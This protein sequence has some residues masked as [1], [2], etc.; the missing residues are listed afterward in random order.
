KSV[1]VDALQSVQV[2]ESGPERAMLELTWRIS[3]R[4]RIVQRMCVYA[5]SPRIDFVTDVDWHERQSLLK[6]AFPTSIRNRRATYEIQ[7][8]T[9]DR[10]THRNT[11][12]EEAAFEV[13][14]QRWADLSDSH[15]GL[16]VLADCKHGYSVHESTLWLSLLKGAIDPDPDADRGQH[17]FTYSLL[18]HPTGLDQVRRAAYSLTRPLIW[19][20][21]GAHAGGLPTQFSLANVAGGGVVV[22]TA[23][24]AEDE[25]ALIVR[26]YEAEG[27]SH[28]VSLDLGV[29]AGSVD[30]VDLLKRNPRGL[31]LAQDGSV[32]LD[33][34]AREIKT[35]RVRLP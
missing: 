11:S 26:L 8:G 23:K 15:Y 34:R 10:P 3:E 24:W 12:W 22:E 31:A 27:G 18:P 28:D 25:D 33:F 4:T 5:R 2:R 32:P 13:P 7:F 16:A 35:M 19:R 1:D 14:A 20:R 9:I 17:H 21:E 29:R 6:V 30:Q